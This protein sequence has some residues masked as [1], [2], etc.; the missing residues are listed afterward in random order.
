MSESNHQ[1]KLAHISQVLLQLLVQLP[2]GSAQDTA[3][4]RNASTSRLLKKLWGD[5]DNNAWWENEK[6]TEG[7]YIFDGV[8][9]E[10]V[11]A[12]K[13]FMNYKQNKAGPI[14]TCKVDIFE[15]T[16]EGYE[17]F[18]CNWDSNVIS[19]DFTTLI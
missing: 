16:A 4:R 13:S 2:L 11:R 17:N 5:G 6:D 14:D 18:V 19:Y 3:F 8:Q 9:L 15:V 12:L 1:D 10:N 7:A